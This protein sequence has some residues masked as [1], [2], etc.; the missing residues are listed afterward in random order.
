M[1]ASRNSGAQFE[2]VD[3]ELGYRWVWSGGRCYDR[4]W[5][6]SAAGECVFQ[7][8]ELDNLPEDFESS[9]IHVAGLVVACYSEEFSHFLASSSLGAWLK[10]NQVPAIY[11]VDTRA[12]TKRIREKG[13]MLGWINVKGDVVPYSDPNVLNLV[14]RVSIAESRLYTPKSV[15]KREARLHPSG[16]PLRVVAPDP[17]PSVPGSTNSLGLSLNGAGLAFQSQGVDL[18]RSGVT[19]GPD[20]EMSE[21]A[22]LEV[23]QAF[24]AAQVVQPGKSGTEVVEN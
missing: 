8:A 14:E 16:R 11:G 21:C 22:E 10:E 24:A 17:S 19:Y 15:S 12:L 4:S 2:V 23:Q 13:S 3:V 7:T 9:K 18:G 5:V 6:A 1:V 20:I